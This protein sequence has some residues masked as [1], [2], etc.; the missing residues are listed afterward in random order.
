V[1][2]WRSVRGISQSGRMRSK[3][4]RMDREPAAS[5]ERIGLVGC[6]KSKRTQPTRAEDLYISPLFA[7]RRRWVERTC[8]R[9]FILSA[10]YGLV[11]P[12]QVVEP[13]DDPLTDK[14]RSARRAWAQSVIADLQSQ[15][16]DLGAYAFEV[17]AGAAYCDFGLRDRLVEAGAAVETPACHLTQGK[18]LALYRDGPPHA[19]TG[20][21]SD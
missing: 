3:I 14:S 19:G 17:H 10:K 1:K 11:A 9:W 16:Q 6:V 13:Y 8:G 7:G 21:L 5:R 4:S 20:R 2:A 18:Q 15:L 12:G